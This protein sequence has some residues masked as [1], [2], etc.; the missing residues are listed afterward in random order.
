MSE[1][2]DED[3]AA[4]SMEPKY[5]PI[6]PPPLEIG[7]SEVQVFVGEWDAEGVFVYQAFNDEIADWALQHQRFGGPDFNTS[8]M[9]WIK[10]SFGWVLYRS[11][12]GSKH[13]QNRVLKV[14]LPHAALAEILARCQCVDTN[15]ATREEDLIETNEEGS[16]GRVQ[17]DPERD[18][19][20]ADGREP[21]RMLRRRAI[22]IGMSGKLSEF[23][24]SSTLSI[25]DVT[26]LAHRI[27]L[28]HRSKK[29]GAAIDEML[30]NLEF[31]LERPYMPM[32]TERILCNLGMLPGGT[33][34]AIARIGRGKAMAEKHEQ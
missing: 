32:C 23:Y 11:G 16:S 31:P 2:V 26:R 20:S 6:V 3:E 9:T 15:K 5:R 17:W 29:S 1:H 8:R 12:Y 18:M 14:K 21:R 22:Q 7:D 4:S 28:A 33:A 13:G 24:V 25:Q 10:P 19:L 30:R 34:T 27:K